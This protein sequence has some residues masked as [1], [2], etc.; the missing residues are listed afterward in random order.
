MPR[1]RLLLIDT[2]VVIRLHQFGLWETVIGACDVHLSRGIVD[3]ARYYDDLDGVRHPIDLTACEDNGQIVVHG[4]S[5]A[6]TEALRKKFGQD[7]LEKLDAGE[8]ELLAVLINRPFDEYQICSADRIVYRV[9]GA[10]KL[11]DQGISLEEVFKA[12]GTTQATEHPYSKAFREQWS[13]RG[14]E[15]GMTGMSSL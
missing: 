12:I 11:S 1:L 15:E 9:L 3:E 5:L 14:F 6:E 4:V 7:I 2:V 8:A 13:R 10:L